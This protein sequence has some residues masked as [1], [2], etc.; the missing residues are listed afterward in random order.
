MSDSKSATEQQKIVANETK[1]N[2]PERKREQSIGQILLNAGKRALGGGIPGAAAMAIQVLALMWLRTT[3]NY[4]YRHGTTTMQALRTLYAEGGIVRFYRGLLPALVQGPASRFGDTA[5]NSGILAL[6]DSLD[7]TRGLPVSVKTAFCSA[8]AALW[9]IVLMPVDT[10]KTIMQVEG[11]RGF[12]LLMQKMKTNGPTVLF[13][14]AIGASAATMV[15]HYPWFYTYNKLNEVLPRQDGVW[16]K[17]GRN[18]VIG[19]TSS[20]VSDTISNS[21]RVIKTTKQTTEKSISYSEAVK[22]VIEK[23]GM[24][25]LFGRGLKTRLIG[26]GLQG[27]LFTVI[28]KG[29]EEQFVKKLDAKK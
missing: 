24:L 7:S 8:T 25:G 23:D 2:V 14:G 27:L 9:R 17:L 16:G 5:A 19:F 1:A 18:A 3:M 21:L 6:L 12:P 26:N 10:C 11:S 20:V 15:G 13:H 4:Q 29:L 22:L 28:W